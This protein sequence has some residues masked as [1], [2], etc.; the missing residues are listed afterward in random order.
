MTRSFFALLFLVPSALFCQSGAIRGQVTD[1]RTGES[2]VGANIIVVGSKPGHGAAT[3]VNGMFLI[4]KV[5]PG[6]YVLRAA[7]IGY[8][9]ITLQKVRVDSARTTEADFAMRVE[10]SGDP[11]L[12]EAGKNQIVQE[13]T[14][15]HV[16]GI[17]E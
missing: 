12:E 8:E 15:K 4:H 3:D 16:E 1:A 9:T 13:D 17:G 10:G 7:Y 2:L 6:E 14:T 11:E 5:P